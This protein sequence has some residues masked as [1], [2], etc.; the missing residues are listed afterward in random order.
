MIFHADF[1]L[2]KN[3][4][5]LYYMTFETYSNRLLIHLDMYNAV[6]IEPNQ[7]YSRW[8]YVICTY[9]YPF[10]GFGQTPFWCFRNGTWNGNEQ[11]SMSSRVHT[12]KKKNRKIP[13]NVATVEE[14]GTRLWTLCPP[15]LCVLFFFFTATNSNEKFFQVEK[16]TIA[17]LNNEID[18]FRFILISG[19]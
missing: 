6:L 2:S 17:S 14:D 12:D 7:P 8:I 4:S 3:F 18:Q 19:L 16:L 9:I 1:I 11:H 15:A 5:L 10:G 13:R